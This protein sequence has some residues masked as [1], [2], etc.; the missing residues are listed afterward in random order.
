MGAA[1]FFLSQYDK[2]GDEFFNYI[3]TG[4]DTWI[5]HYTPETKRIIPVLQ[6]NRGKQN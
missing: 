5:S 4:D 2:N 6:Q 3:V 1:L